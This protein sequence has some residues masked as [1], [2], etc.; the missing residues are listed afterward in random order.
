M[1]F[2]TI[3]YLK[4][5]T[6]KQIQ[7]FETLTQNRVLQHLS[8]FNPV[9]VGTIPINIDIEK[10]DLDIICYWENKQ[11]FIDS[12]KLYFKNENHFT[13]RETVIDYQETVIA[14]FLLDVFEVELFGQNI[15][16]ENQNG[17]K[18]MLVE[19]EILKAK[20]EGFR[21]EIIKLKEQGYKTE[22]AFCK[23][24]GLTGNPYQELLKYSI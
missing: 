12:I 7:A 23:L 11:E 1:K 2:L 15:P 21:Q 9:L 16:V 18:H 3:N 5:G 4:Y 24:L 22:P 20:G 8:V 14:N 19:Y 17:Y 6:Q 13:I 10:S